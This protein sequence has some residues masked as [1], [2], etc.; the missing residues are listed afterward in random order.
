MFV[1]TEY[2]LFAVFAMGGNRVLPSYHNK[3]A[4]AGGSPVEYKSIG[5]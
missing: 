3:M 1:D 4:G 5:L 2:Q